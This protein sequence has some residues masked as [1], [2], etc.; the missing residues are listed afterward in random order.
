MSWLEPWKRENTRI[1]QQVYNQ[2]EAPTETKNAC[3]PGVEPVWRSD[4]IPGLFCELDHIYFILLWI[5]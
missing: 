3:L 4:R 2:L 1:I 5:E